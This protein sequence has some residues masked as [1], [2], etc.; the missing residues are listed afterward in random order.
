M[1]DFLSMRCKHCGESVRRLMLLAM[2]EDAGAECYPSALQCEPGKDHDF[3]E[4][5]K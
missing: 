4:E 2:A 1:S 5:P 3:I